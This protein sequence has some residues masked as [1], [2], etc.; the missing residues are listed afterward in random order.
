VQP[1]STL[2][3][4]DSRP[5][6]RR[7]SHPTTMLSGDRFGRVSPRGAC[8]RRWPGRFGRPISPRVATT[9]G[10]YRGRAR[11]DRPVDP[12]VAITSPASGSADG[13]DRSP[14]ES[15]W[16][17]PGWDLCTAGLAGGDHP[18]RLRPP[19]GTPPTLL[20]RSR[21]SAAAPTSQRLGTAAAEVLPRRRKENRK[22]RN[23]PFCCIN[24][25]ETGISSHNCFPLVSDTF[26][27]R[28]EPL[29]ER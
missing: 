26:K 11:M 12:K 16:S 13:R 5:S 18:L 9:P 29:L 6:R 27:H 7:C 3:S 10:A 1:S 19:P 24:P 2:R 17:K 15:S 23:Q 8:R 28:N 25:E 21:Y 22:P 4:V 14:P 20:P